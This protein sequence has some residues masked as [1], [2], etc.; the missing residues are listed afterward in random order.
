MTEYNGSISNLLQ[1]VSQQSRLERRPE[2][3]E[4]QTNC[5][6]SVTQNIGKRPGSQ[7]LTHGSTTDYPTTAA[8]HEY[9][10]GDTSERYSLVVKSGAIRVTDLLDGAD[11]TV[12]LDGH[13]AYLASSDPEADFR[14]HTIADTTFI[15]NKSIVPAMGTT[16]AAASIWQSIIYCSR[17]S[18]G[19]TYRVI[20]NGTLIAECSTPSTVT[21]SATSM[22][23]TITLKTTDIIDCLYTGATVGLATWN[24]AGTFVG[25]VSA[26]A[27]ANLAGKAQGDDVIYLY[28]STDRKIEVEDDNHG[29]DLR[30]FGQTIDTYDKLPRVCYDGYKVKVSGLDSTIYNDYYVTFEAE[31]GAG[32][33][34]GVWKESAGFGVDTAFDP[35]TMPHTLIPNANRTTFTL[36]EID[37]VDRQAGDDDTNPKPSFV[38]TEISDI[39]TYQGRLVLVSEENV[40]ASGTFDHYNFFAETVTQESPADPIDSASSD[41]Q[42]TNLHNGLV[43]NASLVLFSDRAQFVHPSET[44]F[45]TGTFGLSSKARFKNLIDCAPVASATSIFFPYQS[46]EFTGIREMQVENVTGNL[47]A[48]DTTSHVDHY[49]SGTAEQLVSSTDYNILIVRPG[50]DTD[51]LYVFQWF[52]QEGK[53]KQAAWHRWDF[54]GT[55]QHIALI[56][57]KLYLWKQIGSVVSIEYLDLADTDTPDVAFPVRLDD[58]DIITA[59]S[60]GTNWKID[61]TQWVTTRGISR[62]DLKVVAGDDTGIEGSIAEYSNHSTDANAFV[63]PKVAVTSVGAPDF[64]VGSTISA[65]G[66]LTNPYVRDQQGKPKTKSVLRLGSMKFNCSNTGALDI[67]VQK[68]NSTTYT[69]EFNARLIDNTNFVLDE[70]PALLDVEIRVPVR[71]DSNRCSITFE[72]DSHLPFYISSIDWTG[73]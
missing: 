39:L 61:C 6:S 5:F 13:G 22:D 46:G 9:D 49:V 27:T 37:W 57:D 43:F 65:S 41:N 12:D 1:G 16:T 36:G 63:V 18:Y 58:Q 51:A 38:G 24:A 71:S 7:I 62:S 73:S 33:G 69:K 21:I 34:H 55:V 19:M 64:I 2:Q 23:K 11:K 28:D 66:E 50:S 29:N 59:S 48:E 56:Q 52:N 47:L 60:D 17:A 70:P 26:W 8:Y 15:L 25:G 10:R 68:D 32:V 3:L 31:N 35:A 54:E 40:V 4:S 72:S 42:V 45:T 20:S 67:V 53:R 30:T 44:P 14:F